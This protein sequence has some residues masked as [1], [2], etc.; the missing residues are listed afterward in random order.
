MTQMHYMPMFFGDLLA[1]TPTWDGE[2]RGLYML[3]LAYQWTSGPL[4]NDTKRIAKMCQVEHRS[5]IRLWKT[6]GTKFVET[7]AGFLNERLEQH[8]EKSAEIATKRSKAGAEG[9]AKRW[10]K[11]SQTNSKPMAN[12]I[13]NAIDLSCH[14][15]QSN[16]EEESKSGGDPRKKLFDLGKSILGADAGSLISKAIK[17]SDEATVGRVLAEMALSAKADP[18]SYFVA[19]T[20]PKE[21]GFVC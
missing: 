1:S 8:R 18:R 6:V 9:A 14:P 5:F 7:D 17:S 13:A 16:K 21:R 11:L 10:Q 19:A 12:A 15:S 4:P 2:E 20:K 3:L